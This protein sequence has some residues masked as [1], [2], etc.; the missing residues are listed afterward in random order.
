LKKKVEGLHQKRSTQTLALWCEKYRATE[1]H[2]GK[3]DSCHKA[4]RN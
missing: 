2:V 3:Q 4:G 1:I